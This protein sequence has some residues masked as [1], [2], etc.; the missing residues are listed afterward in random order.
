MLI[1]LEK[2]PMRF[3]KLPQIEQMTHVVNEIVNHTHEV[4]NSAVEL[5]NRSEENLASMQKIQQQ[6]DLQKQSTSEISDEIR[7]IAKNMRSLTQAVDRF[8]V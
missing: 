4:S 6:V 3:I 7:S 8:Q 1:H 5:S 2:L